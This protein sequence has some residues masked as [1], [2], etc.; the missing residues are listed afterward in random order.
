MAHMESGIIE[1]SPLSCVLGCNVVSGSFLYADSP[2]HLSRVYKC[3]N[4]C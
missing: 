1:V 3:N 2:F 4:L